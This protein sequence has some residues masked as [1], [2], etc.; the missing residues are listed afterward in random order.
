MCDYAVK[1]FKKASFLVLKNSLQ[2]YYC[3]TM[4][5]S[6]Q[7]YQA[8]HIIKLLSTLHVEHQTCLTEYSFCWLYILCSVTLKNIFDRF[9]I[10]LQWCKLGQGAALNLSETL[11][12]TRLVAVSW[13]WAQ[14]LWSRGVCVLVPLIKPVSPIYIS[15]CSVLG[16]KRLPCGPL[17]WGWIVCFVQHSQ[18][19]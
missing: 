12:S 4:K 1:N 19:D 14:A 6:L 11:P 10:P 7:E 13:Q 18:I 16:D 17:W 9:V 3:T 15:G 8:T 5:V 2:V